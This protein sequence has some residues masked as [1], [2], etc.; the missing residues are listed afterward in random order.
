MVGSARLDIIDSGQFVGIVDHVGNVVQA[1]GIDDLFFGTGGS[2][3]RNADGISTGV[4]TSDG[5][6]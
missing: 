6:A 1:V 4:S 2:V 3:R 5:S